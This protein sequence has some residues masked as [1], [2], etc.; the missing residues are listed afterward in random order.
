MSDWLIVR[1]PRDTESSLSWVAVDRRGQLTASA[2]TG[3][4][5]DL[6][7]AAVNH[8]VALLVPGEDVLHLAAQLPSGSESKLGQLLPF[9]LEEQIA[10]DIES[11]HFAVGPRLPDGTTSADVVSRARM[12]EWLA[13]QDEWRVPFAAVHSESEL[14]PEV[15]GHIVLLIDRDTLTLRAPGRRPVL[16]PMEDLWLSLELGLGAQASELAQFHVVVHATTVDWQRHSAQV[17]ALRDRFASLKVQLLSAGVL[18]FLAQHIGSAHPINLR[19]GAYAPPR[20]LGGAWSRWKL[21]ASLAAALFIVH[22]AAQALEWRTLRAQEKALDAS[23]G[24]TLQGVLPGERYGADLRR[25]LEA[26][27]TAAAANAG[28]RDGLLAM[29]TEVAQARQNSPTARVEAMTF[30][31]GNLEMRV[32]G[33]DAGSLDAINQALRNAGLKSDLT[34]GSPGKD[35]YEGR[36]Q[37]SA[38]AK[39]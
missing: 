5:G 37:V 25:R 20:E 7:M 10:E 38:G 4:A 23:I 21:A 34:S 24:Q 29:L 27:L 11:Q 30:R 33:P 19:Q 3:D 8:R 6:A 12:S 2:A 36:M 28:Q 14:L 13:L 16:L 32:R 1:L 26:R 18:P 15:E 22:V 17:E 39:G 9:A 31:K 35:S